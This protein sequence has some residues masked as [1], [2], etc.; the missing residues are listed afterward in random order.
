MLI[1]VTN[2]AGRHS[3][4]WCVIQNQNATK[5]VLSIL[6]EQVCG[7]KKKRTGSINQFYLLVAWGRKAPFFNASFVSADMSLSSTVFRGCH[8]R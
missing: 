2:F 7:W 6:S 8:S 5:M 3:S 4:L 1:C